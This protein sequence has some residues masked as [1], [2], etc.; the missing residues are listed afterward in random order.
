[1]SVGVLLGGCGDDGGRTSESG[2]AT[3]ATTTTMTGPTSTG[4]VT[5]EPTT[6]APTGTGTESMTGTTDVPGTT[7]D[8]VTDA[9][10]T[11]A[12]GPNQ[13]P[14]W[15]SEPATEIVIE[16]LFQSN[17]EPGQIFI[18]SSRTDEVRVYDGNSLAFVQAFTH[19][20]FSTVASDLYTYGPNGAAFNSRGNLVV[21]GYDT[22]VEFSD[23][24]VEYATYPKI[25]AEA[26]ENVIFDPRGN[27]YTTTATGGTDK[28]NQYD[29]EDY[30]FMQ[31]IPLPAGAGQLTGITFDGKGRLYLASQTDNTIH[32]ADFENFEQ[33]PWTG[34]LSGAGNPGNFEGLQFNANG[35]LVA[36]AGDLVRYDVLGGTKLGTFDQPDDAFPVPLRVDNEGNIYTSD[37]ENGQGTLAADIFKFA[38]DGQP[39]T[40]SNDPGLFGP[41]GLAISGTVLAGD[42][43]VAWFYQLVATDPD[44]DPLTYTLVSGPPDMV[45]DPNN[46]VL[47]WS[48]TSEDIGEHPVVLSVDDGQGGVTEQMFV[49]IVKSA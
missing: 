3:M 35:E 28:L 4:G 2:T 43:P 17:F 19:P 46:N 39:L 13:P 14:E 26:T 1:M 49:L 38:P 16:E 18:S 41:F 37:Y 33:F 34:T 11:T 20:A 8:A 40:A 23:Y 42:P 22:F 7:T 27:L 44:G 10:A 32:V 47:S 6:T 12:V 9:T 36:A 24:G 21:A 29:A 30:A 15:D 48:V 5:D 31:Q 25:A 45:L